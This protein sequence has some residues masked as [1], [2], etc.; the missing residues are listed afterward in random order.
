VGCRDAGLR[1]SATRPRGLSVTPSLPTGIA[2]HHPN[3]KGPDMRAFAHCADEDS[4]LHP[5]IPDQ[6]LNLV[7]RV[8]YPSA[9][10][11]IVRIVPPGGRYGRIG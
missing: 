9:A 6:A 1:A 11:Q 10:R 7:T 2:S 3:E 4:S 5:V 8:S